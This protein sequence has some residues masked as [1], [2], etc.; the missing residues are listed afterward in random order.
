MNRV[1]NS[2]T[3]V[4]IAAAPRFFLLSYAYLAILAL[5]SWQANSL[6]LLWFGIWA[7]LLS[8]SMM[9]ALWHQSTIRRHIYSSQFQQNTFLH[10]WNSR[11][12][13]SIL[14]L[15]A[16]AVAFSA[17]TLFQAAYFGWPEWALLSVSPIAFRATYLWITSKT[18][19][20]FSK[21]IYTLRW[22]FSATQMV[23]LFVLTIL[24]LCVSCIS[25]NPPD[26]KSVV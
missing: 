14:L 26:R 15:S 19:S 22:T 2:E 23:F 21:P 13:I 3:K 8:I 5:V 10:R 16:V 18:E 1:F 6:N 25:A 7:L 20:Q 17:L 9:L 12:V 4:D 24:F 11:R